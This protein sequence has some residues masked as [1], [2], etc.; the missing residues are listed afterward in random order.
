[1]RPAE[2]IEAN[3]AAFLLELGQAGGG[4]GRDDAQVRW[5]IGGSP[6]D[7]HN[8]VVHA[9]LD[10]DSADAAVRESIE[11]MR[12]SDVPGSWHVGPSMRPGDLSS[13]LLAAGFVHD[14]AEPGMAAELRDLREDPRSPDGVVV[15]PVTDEAD[16]A[17]W[18]DTLA[19]GFGEGVRE[20]TWVA[21]MYRRLGL[22][23]GSWRLYLARLDGVPVGTTSVY[24]GAGVAGVYFVMTVPEARGRGIGAA[25]TIAGLR[26]ALER[27][28]DVAVLTS[29]PMGH[30]VYERIGFREH[31]AIDLYTWRPGP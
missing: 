13:R 2:W 30:K 31:C 4:E 14:G 18:A 7:Y 3:T 28:Y 16:L 19:R 20:A 22:G 10:A 9:D 27:G 23:A 6:L 26:P 8:A 1:M 15:T 12:R 11:A 17:V 24:L 25:V 5:T 29:S 21:E